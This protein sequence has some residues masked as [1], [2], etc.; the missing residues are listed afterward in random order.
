[1]LKSLVG[2]WRRCL[3]LCSSERGKRFGQL[4]FA[5]V[6]GLIGALLIMRHFGL[7]L[8]LTTLLLQKIGSGLKKLVELVLKT[9]VES[10]LKGALPPWKSGR[11]PPDSA[12]TVEPEEVKTP[13][14][15][16]RS[17]L[18][19]LLAWLILSVIYTAIQ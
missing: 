16:V 15:P 13:K 5:A 19:T 3:G 6:V 7:D 18:M 1:M 10:G 4:G 11:E 2:C 8:S 14:N 17:M 9:S 12:T